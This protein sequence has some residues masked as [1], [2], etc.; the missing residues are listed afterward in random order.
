MM[1]VVGFPKI[2]VFFYLTR[3]KGLD[4]WCERD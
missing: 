4:W 2:V 3:T 1:R